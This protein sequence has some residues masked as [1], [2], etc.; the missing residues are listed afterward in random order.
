MQPGCCGESGVR[1]S[2]G[3]WGGTEIP[4]TEG[5]PATGG[6]RLGPKAEPVLGG[7]NLSDLLAH[8]GSL[9]EGPWQL[10]AGI[11]W[12]EENPQ[13][14]NHMVLG[15]CRRARSQQA[16]GLDGLR[17]GGASCGT[18]F[19]LL[20]WLS[21]LFE[22]RG[23]WALG[24]KSLGKISAVAFSAFRTLHTP[25]QHPEHRFTEP[26]QAFFLPLCVCVC[27]VGWGARVIG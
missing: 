1:E 23:P 25:P 6:V 26:A 7:S 17:A 2:W 9:G 18:L 20:I 11:S 14:W 8:L 3:G 27:C 19:L 10:C 12:K 16:E 21:L 24:K 13:S 22:V 15:G 4:Q 5:R